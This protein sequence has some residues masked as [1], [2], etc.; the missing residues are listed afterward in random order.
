MDVVKASDIDGNLDNM[1]VKVHADQ[2]VDPKSIYDRCY[3]L[4]AIKVLVRR[5]RKVMS[6]DADGTKYKFNT[7][8]RSAITIFAKSNA[9]KNVDITKIIE[10]GV[11]ALQEV[12]TRRGSV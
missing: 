5:K 1:I 10:A 7:D 12:R 9:P 2:D 8:R 11:N 3:A 4:G 6:G